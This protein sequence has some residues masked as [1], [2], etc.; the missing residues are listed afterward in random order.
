MMNTVERRDRA[1]TLGF[2]VT[3]KIPPAKDLNH[4]SNKQTKIV[5][6]TRQNV[7]I[8]YIG[9]C[10][11]LIKLTISTTAPAGTTTITWSTEA[12]AT[13]TEVI[14]RLLVNLVLLPRDWCCDIN[15]DVTYFSWANW[16]EVNP[17]FLSRDWCC[18]IY[19]WCYLLV[20]GKLTRSD[21]N[22]SVTWL[23]LWYLLLTLLTCLGQTD[24]KWFQ[25]FY[26]VTGVVIFIFDASCFSR[27]N[28]F[29]SFGL[30]RSVWNQKKQTVY[31]RSG[32]SSV[33]RMLPN[34]FS[35]QLF[36]DCA[37]GIQSYCW[38]SWWHDQYVF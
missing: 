37:A 12:E 14:L 23:V 6:K 5:G 26:H 24:S 1:I 13:T 35:P 19:C 25:H 27:V 20:L 4:R 18:D 29:Q 33:Q 15:V 31:P 9:F 2:V 38:F 32:R 7:G 10:W 36:P 17:T 16:L 34:L 22:I 28:Y 3:V 11:N 30:I 21:F 8:V